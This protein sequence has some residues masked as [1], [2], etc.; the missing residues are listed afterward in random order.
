MH[1]LEVQQ[2][3]MEEM[4]KEEGKGKGKGKWG[5]ILGRVK[6]RAKKDRYLHFLFHL[7]FFFHFE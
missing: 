7:I 6:E 4:E 5:G 1:F 2:I 3:K